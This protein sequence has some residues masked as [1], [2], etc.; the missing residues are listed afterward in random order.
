MQRFDLAPGFVL[1][2]RPYQETSLL[3][4]L[5]TREQG[6]FGAIAKGARRPKSRARGLLQ[7]FIPLLL[8][9]SGRGELLT[10]REFENYKGEYYLPGSWL[11]FGFYV[12]ELIHRL[13]HRF[14]PHP[15]L[16][17]S[18]C[19]VLR[20]LGTVADS[21]QKI[22]RLFEKKLL[23]AIGYELT[24]TKEA[25]TERPIDPDAWY[26]FDPSLGLRLVEGFDPKADDYRDQAKMLLFRGRSL[27]AL[28][29]DQLEDPTILKEAK[30]L[31]R[32]A[33]G[34]HLG[35]RPLESRKLL[36]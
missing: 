25:L 33:L 6:R 14:D 3:L 18:Y 2:S 36:R 15:E 5:F 27:L 30:R 4:E 11:V 12:N 21:T 34:W 1:H 20:A 10:L 24:L 13:L 19:Q 35:D 29:Q 9:C 32:A 31:M 26:A 23:K 22:L 28:E 7:P 16:F 8:S 17:D